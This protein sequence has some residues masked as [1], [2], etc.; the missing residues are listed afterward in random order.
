MSIAGLDSLIELNCQD[1][2]NLVSKLI[3]DVA[4]VQCTIYVALTLNKMFTKWRKSWRF[5]FAVWNF[6]KKKYILRVY[7][8]CG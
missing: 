5:L 3:K 1:I 7:K 6:R 4:K 8:L 2:R